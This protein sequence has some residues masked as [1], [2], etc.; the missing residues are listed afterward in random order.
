MTTLHNDSI[1]Q[2][3]RA[4]DANVKISAVRFGRER[5]CVTLEDER[6]IAVPLWWY[7]RLYHATSAQ[8]KNWEYCAGNR[9][10]HWPEIDEDLSAYG[11]INGLK[12]PGAKP[13]ELKKS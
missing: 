7:P 1:V 8:R 2:S 10:I 13:P 12:A 5:I 6:E 11:F 9:G 4:D 3:R